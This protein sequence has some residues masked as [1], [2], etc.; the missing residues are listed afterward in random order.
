VLRYVPMCIHL[1]RKRLVADVFI[2]STC[3]ISA[4]AILAHGS[5]KQRPRPHRTS[6]TTSHE[7]GERHQ[8][9]TETRL[10]AHQKF[11]GV[12]GW[13]WVS[14]P[15]SRR[16][17]TTPPRSAWRSASVGRCA[18][19]ARLVMPGASGRRLWLGASQH[20]GQCAPRARGRCR[21]ALCRS[22]ADAV[23]PCA[24]GL[25]HWSLQL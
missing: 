13:A 2:S 20:H 25:S 7:V 4:R 16:G 11:S 12:W 15:R 17:A 24:A 3:A 18:D 19:A 10:V 8:V 22:V 14:A 23:L 1:D 6:R 9:T 5:S 21:F